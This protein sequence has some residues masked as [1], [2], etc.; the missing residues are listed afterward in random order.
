LPRA[1]H[2]GFNT[3]ALKPVT[4]V[5]AEKPSIEE[6]VERAGE[7]DVETAL[8]REFVVSGTLQEPRIAVWDRGELLTLGSLVRR[9]AANL[10]E[11]EPEPSEEIGELLPMK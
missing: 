3:V 1:L 9:I 7:G 6:V 2:F 8:G 10:I 11:P 5:T 4:Q